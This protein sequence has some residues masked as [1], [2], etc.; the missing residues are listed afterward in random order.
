M[1]RPFSPSIRQFAADASAPVRKRFASCPSVAQSGGATG[2]AARPVPSSS[3]FPTPFCL[4]RFGPMAG[5][6]LCRA[7][8]SGQRGQG[9]SRFVAAPGPHRTPVQARSGR[10]VQAALSG[11]PLRRAAGPIRTGAVA[12]C[13]QSTMPSGASPVS[14]SLSSPDAVRAAEAARRRFRGRREG[15]SCSRKS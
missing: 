3:H 15:N 13:G 14:N 7:G 5:P 10:P 11:R 12:P 8:R 9:A 6:S 4:W 2:R 1:F